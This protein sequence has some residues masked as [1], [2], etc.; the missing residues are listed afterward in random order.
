MTTS[1]NTPTSDRVSAL[2]RHNLSQ[3]TSRDVIVASYGG[4]GQALVGNMLLELG[5]NYVDAYTEELHRDGTSTDVSA[6]GEY[7]ARLLGHA[8]RPAPTVQW[9]RFVKTHLPARHFGECEFGGVWLLVRDPRDALRSWYNWRLSFAEEEW[10]KVTG[11]FA[12]FLT[13][14]DFGGPTP[15]ADWADFY[16]DWR[17][18]AKRQSMH[19]TIKFEELKSDLESTIQA[20]LRTVN[21]EV[22]STELAVAAERSSYEAMRRR[23]EATAG[24]SE[25]R[26][27]H[28]G[29][30]S[31][32]RDWITPQLATPFRHPNVVTIAAG[33]GYDLTT[34]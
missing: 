3:L 10:D 16:R 7:R 2:Y 28:S 13:E 8:G 29:K 21:V 14:P 4:A 31:G 18:V 22:R 23:E 19:T 1:S 6:H 12:E 15:V 32:W 34:E 24:P 17:A 5:L 9:P 25:A 33:F 20:A 11:T 26:I 30:V 27:M